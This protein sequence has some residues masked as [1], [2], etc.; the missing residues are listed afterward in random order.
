MSKMLEATCVAGIVTADGIP[1]VEAQVLSEGM[2]SSSG[3]LILDGSEAKY[4]AK[5]SPDLKLAL[6]QISTALTNIA[7]A[8]TLLDAKPL[9]T[10]PAAPAAAANIAL[11]TTAQ[12]QIA[13]LKEILK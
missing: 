1:V 6:T 2:G 3:V 7:A 12:A 13:A 9:G 5:T 11:I 10:L 4:I 8:L